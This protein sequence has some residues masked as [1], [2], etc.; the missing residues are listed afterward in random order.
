MIANFSFI[1]A[2]NAPVAQGIEQLPS[3]KKSFQK[4][5]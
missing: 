3:K 4:T 2:K 5:N 1:S